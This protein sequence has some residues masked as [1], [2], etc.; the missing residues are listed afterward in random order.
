MVIRITGRNRRTG[1]TCIS[2]E[3]FFPTGS[4]RNSFTLSYELDSIAPSALIFCAAVCANFHAVYCCRCESQCVRV[5]R[6]IN[7]VLLVTVQADLPCILSFCS[8]PADDSRRSCTLRCLDIN[9]LRTY[10][11]TSAE[12]IDS[13]RRIGTTATIILPG[14]YHFV[15]TRSNIYLIAFK[16]LPSRFS[17]QLRTAVKSN[18]TGRQSPRTKTR[19]CGTCCQVQRIRHKRYTQV[20][21][22]PLTI[23]LPVI[24]EDVAT[25]CDVEQFRCI[26]NR[27]CAI[28]IGVGS[29]TILRYIQCMRTA[30]I[31]GLAIYPSIGGRSVDEHPVV[32]ALKVI[33]IRYCYRQL[34][35]MERSRNACADISCT[36]ILAEI[37]DIICIIRQTI[38]NNYIGI[39]ANIGITC[40]CFTSQC[41]RVL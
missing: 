8:T 18:P 7:Q 1:R 13:C 19:R 20:I 30:M 27:A 33:C 39:N 24:L 17:L 12:V 9:R 11:S 38:E 28:C 10:D 23:S 22:T 37:E 35:R 15:K 4:C 32:A 5:L 31:N 36:A 34:Q 29:T 25:L 40:H 41:I 21:V 3:V 6:Y 26:Y 16:G 14:K 2:V